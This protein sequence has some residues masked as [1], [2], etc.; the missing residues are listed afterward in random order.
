MDTTVKCEVRG[1]IEEYEVE[2][3]YISAGP[4]SRCVPSMI[5]LQVLSL[6]CNLVSGYQLA[7]G[8]LA[9]LIIVDAYKYLDGGGR[10]AA[11]Q[12]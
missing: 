7:A 9:W 6:M 3:E 12:Y 11:L 10:R 4:H 2:V 1:L 8:Q 5:R